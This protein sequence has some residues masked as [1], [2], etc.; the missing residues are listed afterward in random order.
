MRDPIAQV[1]RSI[2]YGISFSV[3]LFG[4]SFVRSSAWLLPRRVGG[5]LTLV[6]WCIAL[7]SAASR[8]WNLL[9]VFGTSTIEVSFI[10]SHTKNTEPGEMIRQTDVDG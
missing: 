9:Y 4:R 7:A 1:S 5:C 8:R 3:Y 10:R 2:L 6:A